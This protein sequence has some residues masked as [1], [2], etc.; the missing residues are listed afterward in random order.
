MIS[1]CFPP[2]N[3]GVAPGANDGAI[4]AFAGARLSSVVREIIQNSL[5]VRKNENEPV[6]IRFSVETIRADE[7][8]GFKGIGPH[9]SACMNTAKRQNLNE[10]VKF[11]ERG[12]KVVNDSKNVNVLCIHDYNT[13]GLTGPIDGKLV[14]G[15]R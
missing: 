1:W 12:I 4:D 8:E 11:Y 5:D 14:P 13:S 7:F 15:S 3:H 9:L 2:N 10:V 6:K